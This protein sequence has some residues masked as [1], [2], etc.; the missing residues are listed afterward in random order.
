MRKS[1]V[2]KLMEDRIVYICKIKEGPYC[3]YDCDNM[4]GNGKRCEHSVKSIKEW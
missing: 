1:E 3:P 4:D 2:K